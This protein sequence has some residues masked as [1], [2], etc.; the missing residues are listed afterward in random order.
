[1]SLD[2]NPR[3]MVTHRNGVTADGDKGDDEYDLTK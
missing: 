2:W 1:M 3:I